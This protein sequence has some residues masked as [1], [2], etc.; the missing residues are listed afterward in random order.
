MSNT[1]CSTNHKQYIFREYEL[2][3]LD[4]LLKYFCFQSKRDITI[5]IKTPTQKT[6]SEF[7]GKVNADN[8]LEDDA[9]SDKEEHVVGEV[10]EPFDSVRFRNV[11]VIGNSSRQDDNNGEEDGNQDLVCWVDPYRPFPL[12]NEILVVKRE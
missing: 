3:F 7:G 8:S 5:T 11:P 9:D 10:D 2:F 12:E 1:S 6:I 4:K